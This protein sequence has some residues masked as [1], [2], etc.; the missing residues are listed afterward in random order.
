MSAFLTAGSAHKLAQLLGQ[1][2]QLR[3]EDNGRPSYP[4]NAFQKIHRDDFWNCLDEAAGALI[5]MVNRSYR[6]NF[7]VNFNF[8]F[9]PGVKTYRV[10]ILLVA[11]NMHSSVQLNG[12]VYMHQQRVRQ[13]AQQLVAAWQAFVATL[14][15]HS[16]YSQQPAIGEMQAMMPP[17]TRAARPLLGRLRAP[18]HSRP[19]GHQL[20]GSRTHHRGH[21]V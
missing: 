11:Y 3:L 5:V 19:D 7:S 10:D 21:H 2:R 15:Q 12:F 17:R 9:A 1:F 16:P 6:L 14:R 20:P 4:L 18:P 8:A 13:S